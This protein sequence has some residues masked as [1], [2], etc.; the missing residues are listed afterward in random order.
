MAT[1][2]H[3]RLT[4]QMQHRKNRDCLRFNQEIDAV[5]KVAEQRT[6]HFAFHLWKLPWIVPDPLEH[7]IEFVKE[8]LG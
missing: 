5:G 2:P 7:Q 8:P 6:P 4:M 1:F 3:I